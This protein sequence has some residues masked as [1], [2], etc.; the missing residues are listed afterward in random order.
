MSDRTYRA[1]LL[2]ADEAAQLN[3][4]ARNGIRRCCDHLDIF[5]NRGQRS[6][7]SSWRACSFFGCECEIEDDYNEPYR[8]SRRKLD[9]I[10][11][12]NAAWDIA[13]SWWVFG[14]V[15]GVIA[16]WVLS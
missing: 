16:G 13:S 8:V 7:G 1:V 9:A 2:R 6:D 11:A 3:E 14:C 15:V 10:L 4:D 12:K 5:H